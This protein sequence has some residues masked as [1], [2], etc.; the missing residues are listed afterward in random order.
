MRYFFFL[1]V[2]ICFFE[3]K[4]LVAQHFSNPMKDMRGKLRIIGGL[5]NRRTFMNGNQSVIY[6]LYCG[7]GL[8]KNLRLKLG[9]NGNPFPIKFHLPFFSQRQHNR[10][11]FLSLGEE[12]SFF[13][14]KRF[15][16][17]SYLQ[18]GLGFNYYSILDNQENVIH[19]SQNQLFP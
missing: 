2:I 1:L 4:P 18:V 14:Y 19:R 12:Y 6:G 15:S 3:S 17:I 10:M 9:V 13:H 16:L 7:V 8:G 5:D 11:M